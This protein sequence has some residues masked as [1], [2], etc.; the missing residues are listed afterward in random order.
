MPSYP[1]PPR[2]FFTHPTLQ[3]VCSAQ[4]LQD[5]ALFYPKAV[6]RA[7][8]RTQ[9][10][11]NQ[12]LSNLYLLTTLASMVCPPKKSQRAASSVLHPRRSPMYFSAP[13]DQINAKCLAKC[14]LCLPSSPRPQHHAD[15]E[16]NFPAG[17]LLLSVVH[18]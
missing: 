2:V 16:S 3:V 17:M 10:A 14:T 12:K 13:T 5:R 11:L 7:K 9:E 15:P 4:L 8:R 6:A 18:P 1:Q